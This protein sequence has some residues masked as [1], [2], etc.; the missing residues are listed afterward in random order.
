MTVDDSTISGNGDAGILA[1]GDITM[2][3]SV[4]AGNGVDT[5]CDQDGIRTESGTASVTGS[6]ITGN[7]D[8]GIYAGTAN[9][10]NST[11]TAHDEEG[12]AGIRASVDVF[13]T[14]ATIT[15]NSVNIDNL[16][17]QTIH[18]FGTV[19]VDAGF[20]NCLGGVA[21]E[22]YNFVDDQTCGTIPAS[23][24]DPKLGALANNGGP[25]WTRLPAADSPL[26]D[27]IPSGDCEIATEQRGLF[28]RPQGAG[29]DIGSVEVEVE[30]VA[31]PSPTPT[32]I[33]SPAPIPSATP[34]PSGS[35]V[36]TLPP[37]SAAV[38]NESAPATTL[39]IAL[40]VALL[41]ASVV[42][43]SLEGRRIGRRR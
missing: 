16:Q 25:T 30:P 26:L 23:L 8:N 36:P 28:A 14:H 41:A 18:L 33:P 40:V 20:A 34:I 13:A 29:C 22:G 10:T 24:V 21:D 17:L 35:A 42:V 39:S 43:V 31:T 3:E 11:I 12:G 1:D 5:E 38:S 4:V 19:L 6:T 9:V 7:G 15:G 2:S 32:P 27:A 37:T